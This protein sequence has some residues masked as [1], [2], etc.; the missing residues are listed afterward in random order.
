MLRRR[1]EGAWLSRWGCATLALLA[2]GVGS[3][4]GKE[5]AVI[6]EVTNCKYHVGEEWNYRARPGEDGSTLIVGKVETTPKLGVI[7]HVSL[8]GLRVKN[9]H[10]P[11]GYSE[12]IAHMPFAEAALENSVTTLA[13]SA[14]PAPPAFS[15]GYGEWRQAFDRGKAGA[16][17]ITVA[18]GVDFIEQTLNR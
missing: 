13:S 10:A 6:S 18:E 7:V 16:F 5:A 17:T 2:T 1:V 15:D 9:S 4:K 12:T 3:C 8:A 11:T 14:V